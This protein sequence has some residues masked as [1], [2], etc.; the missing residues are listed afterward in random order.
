MADLR[1]NFR[2]VSAL[3]DNGESVNITKRGRV[4]ARL[5]PAVDTPKK[6]VKPDIM[7]RLKEVWGDRCFTAAEVKAMR[8]FELEGEDG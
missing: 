7:A 3:I 8:D 5:V 1:N 4:V 6:L 2:R